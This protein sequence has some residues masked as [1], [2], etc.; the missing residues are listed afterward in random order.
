[1]FSPPYLFKG[2]RPTITSAPAEVGYNQT[3]AVA[4]P[5]AAQI[6][7]VTWIRLASVT[8]AFDANQRLNTLQFTRTATGVN[9]KTPNANLAPPGHY[10]L[11]LV[12][13]NGVPSVGRLI[14]ID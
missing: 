8:H 10:L 11:L 4:T 9:V 1:M 13:R 12:N 5:Y 7:K 3:F 6:T 14:H 2:N